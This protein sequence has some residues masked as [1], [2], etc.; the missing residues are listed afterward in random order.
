MDSVIF[1]EF[2]YP[3]GNSV[4]RLDSHTRELSARPGA[5]NT[6]N[7]W[8]EHHSPAAQAY[9]EASAQRPWA[10]AFMK[11]YREAQWAVTDSTRAITHSYNNVRELLRGANMAVAETPEAFAKYII[12]TEL[13]SGKAVSRLDIKMLET[14]RD[15][16]AKEA[17]MADD[18]LRVQSIYKTLNDPTS[19][20]FRSSLGRHAAMGALVAGGVIAL[21]YGAHKTAQNYFGEDSA[22]ARALR[23]NIVGTGLAAS[24]FTAPIDWR[25]RTIMG[26]AGWA[27]GK[28]LNIA[29]DYMFSEGAF[30]DTQL[31]PELSMKYS[32]KR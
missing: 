31:K 30:A 20:A 27:L 25:T 9:R 32:M 26:G 6:I 3:N 2:N 12:D 22:V 29:S 21:D 11:E 10:R 28:G 17:S 19:A 8:V 18:A 5:S 7:A 24:A 23:P 14:A 1:H 15:A 13:T 16:M 4:L